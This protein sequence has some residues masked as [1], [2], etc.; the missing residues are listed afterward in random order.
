MELLNALQWRYATK[1]LNGETVS[2]TDVDQIIQ[3]IQLAPSSSGLQPYQV[4]V[5]TDQAVKQQILPIAFNQA[6]VVDASHLLV[7]A[8]W[9]HYTEERI[10]QV[11]AYTNKERGLPDSATEDYVSLLKNTLLSWTEEQQHHHAAKQAY[12][13]FGVAISAAAEL[14]VDATP[15]EG[16]NNAA[17]DKLLHLNDKGLK[18]CVILP[19]GYRDHEN[20]WL[21]PLKKVRKPLD[22]LIT[23]I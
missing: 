7:F 3:A 22:E 5:I 19:L 23:R 21:H 4:F 13:A 17:L 9:D 2:E 20:D 11:F 14:K 8:A 15:M 10:D 1:K 16:F 18:S 12:I 6:Q